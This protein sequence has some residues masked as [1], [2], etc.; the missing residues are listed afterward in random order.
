MTGP[1]P[2]SPRFDTVAVIAALLAV[3][4][5]AMGIHWMEMEL[6]LDFASEATMAV[7]ALWAVLA[8]V[9][10]TTVGRFLVRR[11]L[12]TRQQLLAMAFAAV[13]AAPVCTQ[14]FWHRMFGIIT[15]LPRGGEVAKMEAMSDRLWPHGPDIGA[16]R[17]PTTVLGGGAANLVSAELPVGEAG[18]VPG[19]PYLASFLVEA[20]QLGAGEKVALRFVGDGGKAVEVCA[21][22]QPS[23][24]D[25]LRT[26]KFQRIGAYN[27]AMP[28]ATGSV[29]LVVE[30]T[31]KG[32][33]TVG[34]AKVQSVAAI[35]SMLAGKTSA[36]RSLLAAHR[37]VNWREWAAPLI[38][39]TTFLAIIFAATFAINAVMRRQWIEAE[40]FSLPV[41][42]AWSILVGGEEGQPSVWRSPWLWG[43]AGLTVIWCMLRW[44]A[45]LDPAFPNLSVNVGLGGYV[46][47]PAFGQM[48]SV[49]LSLSAIAL[50]TALFFELNLLASML[51]GFWLFRAMFWYGEQSGLSTDPAY[52]WQSEQQV[53]SYVAYGL[54]ILLLGRRHLW[55]V[56]KLVVTGTWAPEAGEVMSPRVAAILLCAAAGGAV[57]WGAWTGIS[58]PGLLALMAFLLLVGVVASRLRAESGLLFSMF[59]PANASAVLIAMGGIAAFGA[60]VILM[61]FL[62]SFFLASNIFYI[63]GAQLELIE[64]AKR[65]R[66]RP[67]TTSTVCVVG[68]VGAVV[69]GG[70]FFLTTCFSA[71][72]DHLPYGWAFDTKPW[73][74]GPYNAHVVDTAS[75]QAGNVTWSG[76][77]IGFVGTGAVAAIRQFW[78]GFA[79]HPAGMLFGPSYMLMYFWGSVA[80]AL[81]VRWAAVRFGGAAAVRSYIQ[82]VAIG[83]MVGSALAYAWIAVHAALIVASGQRAPGVGGL[84]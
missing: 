41:G 19:A 55:A 21:L 75:G 68:V 49:T 33:V 61:G 44:K 17:I 10:A 6:G 58:I 24:P 79:L 80:V 36:D 13:L 4:L 45:A 26:D 56:A 51:V 15:T 1:T 31:G 57:A 34:G 76:Y 48:F 53:G 35:E 70:W 72:T 5:T 29:R 52:P 83:L 27:V 67:L 66:I 54:F 8:V 32:P 69:I 16:D 9:L 73:Y 18:A 37:G 46:T 50:G 59:T 25:L 63:A 71:G 74:L 62:A 2:P 40:R 38:A 30:L 28:P 82:P 47:N 20:P 11:Q 77:I 23:K 84:L 14:G 39:W 3:A 60:D 22:E 43:A 78:P 42:R 7:P 65:D 64:F 12:L 81:V